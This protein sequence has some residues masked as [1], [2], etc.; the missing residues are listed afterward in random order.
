MTSQNKKKIKKRN[1]SQV[2][3]D[4]N[5]EKEKKLRDHFS[6]HSPGFQ[7]GPTSCSVL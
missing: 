2:F 1:L 6:S 4:F 7:L 3:H 5:V